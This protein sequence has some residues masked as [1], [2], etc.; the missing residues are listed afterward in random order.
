MKTAPPR[1][2]TLTTPG[3]LI[4]HGPPPEGRGVRQLTIPQNDRQPPAAINDKKA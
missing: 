4:S 1:T 2:P 3:V